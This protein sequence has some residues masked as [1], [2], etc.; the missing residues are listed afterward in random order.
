MTA[1]RRHFFRTLGLGAA[2]TLLPWRAAASVRK[3]PRGPVRKDA[4]ILSTWNAGLQANAKAWATLTA[5]G[6]IL[7]AVEQGVMVIEADLSNRSVGQGGLPDR[8]GH[9]TLDACI[10]DHEGHAGS[11]AFLEGFE[12]PISIARAVMEH[13]PHVMLVGEGARQWAL[14]NGFTERKVDLPE[15]RAAYTEW[16]RT[17]QYKP[18]VNIENHDTIGMIGRDANGRMGGTCTTSGLAYK[19]HGRVGDSPIIGAGLFVDGEVGCA[20]ATGLGELVIRVVGSHSVVELMRQGAS[21]QEAC[22]DVVQRII[23]Q[24]PGLEEQQVGFLAIDSHGRIG[25]HAVYEGFTYAV[26]SSTEEEVRN[27]TFERRWQPAN[28]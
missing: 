15:V 8:D 6:S 13:T 14:A 4:L 25:A 22:Q 2:A 11:V 19:I 1:D 24:N 7:D 27:A 20:C 23:R 12:H 17:S 3:G 26:H 21:P 28:H 10:Q 18:V 16:L 5:G 9:T